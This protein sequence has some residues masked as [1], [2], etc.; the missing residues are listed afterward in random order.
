MSLKRLFS[1]VLAI[2]MLAACAFA[3]EYEP[4]EAVAEWT[5]EDFNGTWHIFYRIDGDVAS[6]TE[7]SDIQIDLVIDGETATNTLTYSG[8]ESV[9]N[10]TIEYDDAVQ[11]TTENGDSADMTLLEDGTLQVIW[12]ATEYTE[13]ATLFFAKVE[14]QSAE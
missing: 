9:T 1:L 13:V 6:S 5:A 2:L 12:P 14:P 4:A 7:G 3:E 11:L 8:G 10:C